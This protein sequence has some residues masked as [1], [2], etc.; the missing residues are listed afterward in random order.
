MIIFFRIPSESPNMQKISLMLEETALPYVVKFVGPRKS[1]VLDAEFAKISPNGTAP[2]IVDTDTGVSLFESGAILYF[3]AEKSGKLLPSSL[4]MRAD[5]IKWLMFEVAN[6]CPTMI[7]LHHYV[8]NDS[9]DLPDAIFQRYKNRLAQ[10]CSILDKQLED[11]E[12]LAGQYSIADIALY[13]W[14]VALEDMADISLVD[15]PNLNKWV[16]EISERSTTQRTSQEN[17]SKTNW[18]YRNDNVEL[19]SA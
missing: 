16:K 7:E 18:C 8:M 13:P 1:G 19:C 4:A 3:L 17:P 5:V 14:T 15:F 2:A 12:Y 10:Y 11:R 6:V 9:G